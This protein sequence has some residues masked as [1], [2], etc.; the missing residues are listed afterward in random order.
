MKQRLTAFGAW[1]ALAML[2]M[3]AHAPAQAAG[4]DGRL[5]EVIAGSQR[6]QADKARDVYRKPYETLQFA[7]IR[8][9]MTV[10]E[11][12]PGGGWYTRILEPY[13]KEKGRY[14][15]GQRGQEYAA[16]GTVDMVLDFRN[17]HNWLR[18]GNATPQ[19]WFKALKA[20]GVVVLEDH[21]AD[22]GRPATA[23]YVTEKQIRAVLEGVGFKYL[24]RSDLLSNPKDTKDYADGV[25]TLPPTLAKGETD[26]AKYLA[27]GESDRMLL[28][29]VKP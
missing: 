27:I 4:E 18:R 23:G 28:K 24:D 26:K 6:S 10:V 7:G 12:G 14:I 3:L 15:A 29:F 2:T 22:E 1:V 8:E 19:T 16:P 13:L 5:R 20:G 21:R 11:D 17:A 9:T 25:W